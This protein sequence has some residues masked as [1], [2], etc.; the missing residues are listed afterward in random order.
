L[1]RTKEFDPDFALERAMEVFWSQGFEAATL[2]DLLYEMGIS[3]Q[4]L[5]DTYGD[6]RTLFLAALERYLAIVDDALE[7]L[8]RPEAT[9]GDIRAYIE[10]RVRMFTTSE[11]QGCLLVRSALELGHVDEEVAHVVQRFM[12]RVERAFARAAQNSIDRGELETHRSALVLGRF[13]ANT[14]HGLNVLA[15]TGS[16]RRRMREVVDIAFDGLR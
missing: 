1:A 12:R 15:C 3:R 11:P 14:L 13:F 8:E 16:S 7:D 6:K 9:L 10:G 5:Y 4:S 2:P